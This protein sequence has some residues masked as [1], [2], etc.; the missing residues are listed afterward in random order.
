MLQPR[1][2]CDW[3]ISRSHTVNITC[4]GS[5]WTDCSPSCV[6]EKFDFCLSQ[7][8]HL[9]NTYQYFVCFCFFPVL[10]WVVPFRMCGADNQTERQM[11]NKTKRNWDCDLISQ[12]CSIR[13]LKVCTLTTLHLCYAGTV[14]GALRTERGSE[15][16][17]LSWNETRTLIRWKMR[18]IFLH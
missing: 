1:W 16:K 3:F 15:N 4:D 17:W 8:L 10:H 9:H 2:Q 11:V 7:L 14:H 12:M 5:F 13:V 18:R 6:L